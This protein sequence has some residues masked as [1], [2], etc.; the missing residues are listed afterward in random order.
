[1]NGV[2]RSLAA[3]SGPV[4]HAARRLT[5]GRGAQCPPAA[6]TGGF[7]GKDSCFRFDPRAA[8]SYDNAL[9]KIEKQADVH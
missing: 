4:Y 1:M 3:G 2:A 9:E 7:R 6:T 8:L 5:I